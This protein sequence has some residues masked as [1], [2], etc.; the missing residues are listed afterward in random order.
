[1][2]IWKIVII[3]LCLVW[4]LPIVYVWFKTKSIRGYEAYLDREN[5]HCDITIRTYE[6]AT[7]D[8]KEEFT[9]LNDSIENQRKIVNG[10]QHKIE[11]M[12][13]EIRKLKK[14]LSNYKE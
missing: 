11:I 14:E 6:I 10:W 13:Y 5:D 3:V 9:R 4:C 8:V 2:M 1:M 12:D 7:R